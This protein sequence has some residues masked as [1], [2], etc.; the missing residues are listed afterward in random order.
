MVVEREVAR[1]RR[2]RERRRLLVDGFREHQDHSVNIAYHAGAGAGEAMGWDRGP[3]VG[4]VGDAVA[5][6]A[7]RDLKHL[8]H[9]LR[10]GRAEPG[11]GGIYFWQAFCVAWKRGPW[12]MPGFAL[13][14]KPPP[15][16]GS[17]KSAMP[18]ERMHSANSSASSCGDAA[19][20]R[21]VTGPATALVDDV[22]PAPATPWLL[23][24]IPSDAFGWLVVEGKAA[25]PWLLV[26]PPPHADRPNATTAA[27]AIGATVPRGQAGHLTSPFR[28]ALAAVPELSSSPFICTLPVENTVQI[29]YT[30][31][32]VT[33][34]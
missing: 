17:G 33:P 13:K 2:R 20:G 11:P 5:T 16:L 22:E 9:R 12:M 7:L 31:W 18:W 8:G 6:H 24:G 4:E 15:L 29:S 19:E 30:K 32:Q 27:T 10:G 23:E 1:G 25:T 34:R 14:M 28:P 21:V 26:A 3:G